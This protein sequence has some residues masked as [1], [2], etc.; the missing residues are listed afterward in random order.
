MLFAGPELADDIYSMTLDAKGR[1]VVSGRGYIRTLHDTDSDG[2]AEMAVQFAKLDHGT[3]G[4][5]FD[6]PHLWAGQP[7][8]APTTMPTP[9]AERTGRP[10]NSCAWPTASTEHTRSARG[11]T[12]GFISSAATTPASRPASLIRRNRHSRKPKAARSFDFRRTAKPLRRCRAAFAIHTILTSTGGA[13]FSRTTATLS[14]RF[15]CRGTCRPGFITRPSEGIMA[16]GCLATSA[17]LGA[18]R[19]LRRHRADAGQ[20]R[21]RL[22]HRRLGL[23]SPID[24]EGNAGRG[25]PSSTGRLA[26][27]GFIRCAPRTPPIRRRRNC[28]SPRWARTVLRQATSRSG[29]M[30]RFTSRSV[31]GE[32]RGLFFV[33]SRRR[34]IVITPTTAHRRWTLR[35]TRS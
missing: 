13:I 32:R 17:Q 8:P 11:R 24:P 9:M 33:L 7:C 31:A 3:M 27:S 30:E 1:V 20:D 5:L 34:K 16:G 22:P 14:G 35:S 28:L 25:V 2:R 26:T 21:T 23:Q 12:A 19:L 4:M 10:G 29:G 15:T 18:A 6:R